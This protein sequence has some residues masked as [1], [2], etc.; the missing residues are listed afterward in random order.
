VKADE[1][2]LTLPRLQ[3][4]YHVAHLVLGGLAVRL[5]LTFE[6]LEDLQVALAGLLDRPDTDEDLTVTL[7][8]EDGTLLT[9]VGPFEGEQ[10]RRD[11][12]SDSTDTVSLG[13]MLETVVDQVDVAE[14]EGGLWVELTKNVDP[15]SRR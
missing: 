13:R 1:I 11:L 12:A 3:P 8:V 15:E 7:R 4:F 6:S 9:T 14:R 2:S 10:L 5:E